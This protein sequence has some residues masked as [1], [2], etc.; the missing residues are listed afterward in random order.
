M[1]Y[2]KGNDTKIIEAIAI[3][4]NLL[5]TSSIFYNNIEFRDKFDLSNV[6]TKT[7]VRDMKYI[8][9][10]YDVE[11][12]GYKPWYWRSKV[13][14]Y[15]TSK[16]PDQIFFNECM[17]KKLSIGSIVGNIIHEFVHLV[18]F[19]NG[20][21]TYHHHK[22]KVEPNSRS[23]KQNTAPYWIG[24]LAKKIAKCLIS[25]KLYGKYL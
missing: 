7:I 23:G 16:K 3:A 6:T 14:G 5:A 2:Y 25:L 12:T 19:R 18:D 9:K 13:I 1:I 21:E 20:M 24:N 10:T 22:T 8:Y 15:Y 17:A 11:Y 4:N